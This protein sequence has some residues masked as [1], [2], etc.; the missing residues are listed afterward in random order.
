MG[1]GKPV[2][3][4]PA[5]RRCDDRLVAGIKAAAP[6]RTPRQIAAQLEAMCEH[7]PRGGTRWHRSSVKHLPGQAERL[8]LTG[9]TQG[10]GSV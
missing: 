9:I 6:D 10:A 5:A 8:G 2:G 1:F 4:R 7:T 3:P